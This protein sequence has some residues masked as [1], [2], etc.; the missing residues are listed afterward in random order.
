VLQGAGRSKPSLSGQSLRGSPYQ[1]QIE[2][3][4]RLRRQDPTGGRTSHGVAV[5][6]IASSL[7]NGRYLTDH[8][9]LITDNYATADGFTVISR[10]VGMALLP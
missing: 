2:S 3:A 8:G 10:F 7:I 4:M 6:S 1:L 9:Q 5:Q